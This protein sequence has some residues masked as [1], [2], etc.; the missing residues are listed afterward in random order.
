MLRLLGSDEREICS[1]LRLAHT[2]WTRMKGLLGTKSLPEGQALWIKPCNQ[3]H[4]YFMRYPVDLI[5]LDADLRI[6]RL[7]DNQPVNSI[8]EK[9]AAAESVVELPVGAIARAGLREGESVFLD[10]EIGALPGSWIETTGFWLTNVLLASWFGLFA[11][12]HWLAG[13]E[14]GQWATVLPI[15]AQET[16]LVV[17]FL[18]RRRSHETSRRPLDWVLGIVGTLLPLFL[19]PLPDWSAYWWVGQPIQVVGL[20]IALFGTISL[21]RSVGVVASNRGVKTGGAHGVVRHP[22]YT[23]YLVGFT[24]YLIV[25]PSTYNLAILAMTLVALVGR[26]IAEER[27]LQRDPT[28]REYMQRVRWRFLPY[29]H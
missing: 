13:V 25:Y 21:G 23:G 24:G 22:M 16:L 2:H 27:L 6:V 12:R 5:F 15:V 10:G 20:A 29:V 19:R 28:Y 7:I 26:A 18:T 9:V 1:E 8:S 11:Y 17:L 14:H 4:M 3:V